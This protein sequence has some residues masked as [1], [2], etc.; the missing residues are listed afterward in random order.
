MQIFKREEK[1]KFPILNLLS[2]SSR[3]AMWPSIVEN[4]IKTSSWFEPY[5]DTRRNP[6][7]RGSMSA[8]VKVELD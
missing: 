5:I 1:L 2:G 8:S 3:R 6:D 7:E 4:P